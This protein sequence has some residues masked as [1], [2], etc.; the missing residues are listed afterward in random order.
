MS[1]A[2]AQATG[3]QAN[4]EGPKPPSNQAS[5]SP[6]IP[7]GPVI[8]LRRP[9]DWAEHEKPALPG[10]P[11]MPHHEPWIRVCYGLIAV[12][13]GLTGGLGNALFTANLPTIQGQLGLTSVEAAWLTGAYVMFNMTANLLVYKFR[14][15]FGMRL[16]TEIGLG[17][18]AALS[19]LH[20]LLGSYDSLIL[21]RAASG[22]AAA[23]CS[24]LSTLYML[25]SAPR[26]YVLK[27]LVIGV[28]VVQL[29]TPLAWILSP[30]LLYNSEWHN[31]YLF[32]AGLALM[33]FAAVVLLKLPSGLYIRT[34][35]KL[36]FVTFSLMVPGLGLLIA[37]LVQ[38]YS[39]W[40]FDTPGLAWMLVAAIALL[41]VALYIEHHRANPMFHT[42]WFAQ[43]PTI[44]FVIGAILLRFL[45]AEQSYGVVGLMRTL[46][47]TSDQMQP[48]FMVILLGTLIGIALSAITFGVPN[49]DKQIV[50]A[51]ALFAV[52]AFLDHHRSSVDRPSDFFF[53]Q[54]LLAVGSGVFM[55]PLMLTG[56]IQG[57]KFGANHM[58]TAVVTISMT[59]AMGGLL[60]SALLST[61]Q[62]YREQVYSVALV[63]QIDP[64]DPVVAE[65]LKIQ[66]QIYG[67][68]TPD[69]AMRANQGALQL[70]QIVR[71]EA[72]VRAYNDVFALT[73]A[74]ALLYL[75]WSLGASA[76]V[77]QAAAMVRA[78]TRQSG[79]Q[80]AAAAGT[81]GT[82][83]RAPSVAPVA[84]PGAASAHEPDVSQ[85]GTVVVQPTAT[86]AYGDVEEGARTE[87]AS[88]A[89]TVVIEGSE[90]RRLAAAAQAAETR[91]QAVLASRD[92]LQ[93]NAQALELEA[94]LEQEIDK[95]ARSSP[96]AGDGGR[97][98][99]GHQARN[100]N[101]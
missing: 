56:I 68:V 97:G 37:V 42:R 33:S 86:D 2:A 63:A 31:L 83:Q 64:T 79:N 30:G 53:S 58:L 99:S 71:R 49:M 28:G 24:S 25:Q 18:Y 52:A 66:G 48:L 72:N 40:W 29:A 21:L 87:S 1:Q 73:A 96:A 91:E 20:L 93:D 36:D 5:A 95:N 61:Y 77:R 43:M 6:A 94:E 81:D 76:R 7:Q 69:P 12:L 78:M 38:G 27:M 46:G 74:I 11:A 100:S 92:P 82:P 88:P 55:G 17:C 23:T 16:F 35:E 8:L 80:V 67:R 60:G 62:T 39:R 50:V 47:M 9:P 89:R 15:Q 26:T 3:A 34:F 41:S 4:Q 65:R 13:V 90:A 44:R 57:L 59:Q 70:S 98:G 32:E 54:F 75:L 14:Q 84:E 85:R 51:I 22:M 45:T 10:S 101:R 19:V